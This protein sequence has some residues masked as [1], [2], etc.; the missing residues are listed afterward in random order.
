[1]FCSWALHQTSRAECC[2]LSQDH[3][4]LQANEP[5]TTFL[6]NC[7]HYREVMLP[8]AH[9]CL[10]GLLVTALLVM[11]AGQGVHKRWASNT[12]CAY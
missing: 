10:G 1:M 2:V 9:R 7:K 8:P 3:C 11:V 4:H 5:R 6:K 12:L